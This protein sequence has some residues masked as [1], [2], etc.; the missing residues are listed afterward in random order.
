VGLKGADFGLLDM[1]AKQGGAPDCD[2]KASAY[3]CDVSSGADKLASALTA[4]RDTVVTTEVHTEIVKHVEQTQLPCEWEIPPAPAGQ[5][6]DR[7]KVNVRF[8][9]AST[10]STFVRVGG[11]AACLDNGWHFDDALAPKRLVACPQA[12]DRIKAAPDAKID[13]LLGCATLLPQ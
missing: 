11:S 13:V 5:L 2:T 8:S 9:S 10:S 6:F 12:C 3:A 7:D 4:I 1:I